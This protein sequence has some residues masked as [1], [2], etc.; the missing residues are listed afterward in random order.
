[1][2]LKMLSILV[3]L[4]LPAAAQERWQVG[5]GAN[6]KDSIEFRN[7]M[8]NRTATTK[9]KATWA[10]SLQLAYRAWDFGT[11]DLSVTGE[12][13]FWTTYKVANS[14]P[15]ANA[16]R[17]RAQFFAPGL[18]WNHHLTPDFH[19]GLGFQMRFANLKEGAIKANHNRPWAD[20]HATYTF[21]AAG[22]VRPYAG[23]RLAR[24]LANVEPQPTYETSL[25]NHNEAVR[26]GMRRLDG[27]WEMSLQAGVRF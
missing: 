11:H 10:P 18:Q 26:A 25:F 13:Q 2:N 6:L 8:G 1:M 17:Y 7:G 9:R 20:L 22:P 16:D 14:L 24:A 4:A 21:P 15:G 23:L 3:L 27:I 5:L 12:Y 19:W